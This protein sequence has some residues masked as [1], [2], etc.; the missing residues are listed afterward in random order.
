MDPTLWHFF[1]LKPDFGGPNGLL[2]PGTPS[3]EVVGIAPY[4]TRWVSQ[5]GRGRLD[6]QIGL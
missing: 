2:P 6:P 1:L 4:L 5:E 3:I